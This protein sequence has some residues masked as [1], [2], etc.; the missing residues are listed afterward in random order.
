[1]VEVTN[2]AKKIHWLGH[3]GFRIDASK[4]IYF[5]PFQIA[6]GPKADIIFIS[7]EHFDHCSPEDIA[8]IQGP[9][10]VIVTEK[11]SASKLKGDVR[12]VKPGDKTEIEGVKVEVVPAYNIGK[13][14][15]PKANGWLGFIVEI[16]GVKIYH[17]GDTDFIPEMK[18]THVDIALLPVSGVYVM[19]SEQAVEAAKAIK[20]KLAIPMHYDAIVGSERDAIDF[21]KALEGIIDVLVLKRE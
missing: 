9:D 21:K 15:H 11:N 12:V 13:D 19:T 10:T 1:M 7:H 18:E 8:K 5:D 4:V 20:P 16:D 17:A 2:F 14:F 6:G 3:D